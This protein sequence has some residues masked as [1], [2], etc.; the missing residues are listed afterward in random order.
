[1]T[2]WC[3]YVQKKI[4]EEAKSKQLPLVIDGDGISSV[5]CKWPGLVRD[6]PQVVLTPN[7]PE[8]KRLCKSVDIN[9]DSPIQELCKAFGNITIVQKGKVDLISNGEV[10]VPCDEPGSSRRCGG[11]GDVTSGAIGTFLS[12]AYAA[13][14]KEKLQTPPGVLA[15]F[16]G[17]VVTRKCNNVA[18][19][20]HHRSMLTADM[21]N[22]IGK[23]FYEHF[24]TL[25][26]E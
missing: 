1:V 19:F 5:V 9:E 2:I 26:E 3:S 8:Y 6:Y 4:I 21:L 15:G 17:C 13:D 18:F 20:R 16:A 14:H 11:Q 10:V 22:E 7:L 23:V 12:W 25:S 24:E